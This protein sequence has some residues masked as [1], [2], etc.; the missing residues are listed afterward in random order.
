MRRIVA[1]LL[2]CAVMTGALVSCGGGVKDVLEMYENSA[3]TK[4]EAKTVETSGSIVLNGLFTITTGNISGKT[5]A[6]Y[7]EKYQRMRDIESGGET[8]NVYG[9]IEDVHNLFHYIDGKGT[10]QVNPETF[11]VISDW[12]PE[13]KVFAINQGVFTLNLKGKYLKGEDY[14]GHT[15]TATV[16]AKHTGSVF[17]TDLG[18]DARLVITDN[19][20]QIVG[21]HIEYTLPADGNVQATTVVIDIKYTYDNE[22]ITIN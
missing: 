11:N 12:N 18:V 16:P 10:R 21:V 17:G 1:V 15:L 22:R 8:A 7:E 14:E 9:E 13:G 4:V 20:A 5:A 2:L 6:V 19:G 3:P